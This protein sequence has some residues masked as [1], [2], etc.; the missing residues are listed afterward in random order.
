MRRI[1]YTALLCVLL[2]TSV[3]CIIP[4]Y[5]A[6]RARRTQQLIFNSEDFRALLNTWERFWFLDQPDHMTPQRVHGGVI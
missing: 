4:I 1:F 2:S 5:S 3:G 6:E